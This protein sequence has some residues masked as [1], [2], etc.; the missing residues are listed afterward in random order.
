MGRNDAIAGTLVADAAS[1]GLHW[2]YDQEQIKTIYTSGDVLF[3]QPDAAV[4]K[5]KK[6][7]FAHGVRHTGELSHYGESARI[8]GQLAADGLYETIEHRQRF[9]EAFGPCGQYHGYADRPTKMLIARM[10]I[11]GDEITEPTG[12]DDNQMPALCVVPGLFSFEQSAE[13]VS[14][15]V[16]VISTN[17]DVV[18]GASAIYHCLDLV[19][20]GKPLSEALHTSADSMNGPVGKLMQDALAIEHYQPLETAQRFGLACYVEHALPVVWHLLNHAKDFESV[21]RDNILCGGDNC[22]R[23][24]ALGAIAGLAFGVPDSMIERMSDRRVPINLKN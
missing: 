6:G 17:S 23:S 19:A 24:M 5:D 18:A 4:Y 22:G 12:M 3:R 2:L 9:F 21:V 1:M 20:Q 15:A 10:L 11:E 7:F 8:A 13:T 16:Q 14:S